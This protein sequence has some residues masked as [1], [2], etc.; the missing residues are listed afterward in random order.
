[1]VEKSVFPLSEWDPLPGQW[2]SSFGE[3]EYKDYVERVRAAIADGWVYQVNACRV[4][5]NSLQVQ[6]LS[7]LFTQILKNNPAPWAS[8]LDIPGLNIASAS[9]ELFLLR[10]GA[11]IRT[12]PIKGTLR[13]D[14]TS[15]GPKDKA[16]N[17]MIV[18][19]MRNDLGKICKLEV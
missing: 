2:R 18:D 17:V 19:L 12:S 16:E 1:M 3:S 14:E 6:S 11:L 13:S 8:Y 10:D 7:G 4:L 5:N 15:F 9:P